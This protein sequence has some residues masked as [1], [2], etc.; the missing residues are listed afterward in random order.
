MVKSELQNFAMPVTY[1]IVQEGS[2]DKKK[3]R[4]CVLPSTWVFKNGWRDQIGIDDGKGN[5]EGDDKAFWPETRMG[6][7][8]LDRAMLGDV[9]AL[10]SK[11]ATKPF[12]CRIKRFNCASNEEVIINMTQI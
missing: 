10:P 11:G 3:T 2:V 9:A 6:E 12:R 5:D 8:D 1:C 4:L 7:N